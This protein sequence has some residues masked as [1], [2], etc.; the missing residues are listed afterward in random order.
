M[1]VTYLFD[2][3]C[4][5]CYGAGPAIHRLAAREDVTLELA[6]TGLFAGDGGRPMDAVFAAYIWQ[7]DQRVAAMT[8][9]VYS[10]AYRRQVLG[11]TGSVLDSTPATLA[12]VAAGLSDPASELAVLERIQLARYEDGL[13]NSDPEVIADMLDKAGYADAAQR[14]RQ[15]DDALLA[16]YETRVRGARAEMARFNA[17]GVPALVAGEGERRRFLQGGHLFGNFDRLTAEL[18][19]A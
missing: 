9:R 11:A 3:L 4:G 1:R 10:E 14:M 2:P 15:P 7:A 13:D 16:A 8:G 5:W 6:P 18:A 19:A 17:E 12:I